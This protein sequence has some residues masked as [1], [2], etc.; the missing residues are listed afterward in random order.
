M[1][2]VLTIL[3]KDIGTNL[4]EDD[5]LQSL[6][7]RFIKASLYHLKENERILF[8]SGIKLLYMPTNRVTNSS[9]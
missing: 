8:N 2:Y 7:N 1:I 5:K 9:S 3:S 4:I 6:E